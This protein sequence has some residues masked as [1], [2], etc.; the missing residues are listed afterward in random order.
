MTMFSTFFQKH[1]AWMNIVETNKRY[2]V[3]SPID[4]GEFYRVLGILLLMSTM[5]CCFDQSI[6]WATDDV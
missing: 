3:D 4:F 5:T 2:A 6:F 1:I